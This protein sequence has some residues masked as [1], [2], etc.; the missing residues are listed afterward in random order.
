[1]THE[2]WLW[3]TGQSGRLDEK[4]LLAK[5]TM[6]DDNLLEF[7]SVWGVSDIFIAVEPVSRHARAMRWAVRSLVQTRNRIAHG[8]PSVTFSAG[9]TAGGI[10]VVQ[11]FCDGADAVMANVLADIAVCSA[12]W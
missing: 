3:R 5:T 2:G 4:R 6:T 9:D 12:P 10:D 11:R 8:D 1:M 7:Y